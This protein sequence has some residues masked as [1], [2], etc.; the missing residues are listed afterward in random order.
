MAVYTKGRETKRQLVALTYQMLRT[1]DAS[2]I[3]VREIA[4]EQ[5]C[6]AA[7]IYRHFESFNMLIAVSSVRFMHE[8]MIKYAELMESERS[9][10]DL[11][12]SGWELFAAYAFERPDLYYR[13]FWGGEGMTLGSVAQ[14]Y[15]D[16]FPYEAPERMAG[17]FDAIKYN[18]NLEMRDHLM[19]Q[20]GIEQGIV[21]E[22]DAWYCSQS[23]A[24]IIRGMIQDAMGQ[25][26]A[27]RHRLQKRS[28]EL[29]CKNT[30]SVL[31]AFSEKQ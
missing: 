30:K 1:R 18:G 6:S 28:Y 8:Y 12:L 5:G 22:E 11:Y 13:L 17:Y 3:S 15:Y 20:Q 31:R 26:D 10:L 14:E 24:L 4:E 29:I 2:S 25:D 27:E 7:A 16:L 9:F 19:M 23:N 21:S